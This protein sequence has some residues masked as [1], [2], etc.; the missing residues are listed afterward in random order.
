MDVEDVIAETL[1][2]AYAVDNW[3]EVREAP[4]FLARIAR[5]LLIDQARRSAII[6][7]DYMADLD[8]LGRAVTYDGM[9]TARDEL[10]RLEKI[11]DSLP[12]QQRRAFLLRRVHGYSISEVA[13]EMTLTVSTIEK[14]LTRALTTIARELAKNED[15]A[16]GAPQRDQ[17]Q[18]ESDRRGSCA[19]GHSAG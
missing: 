9:F 3:Q 13:A 2:R 19:S 16:S 4:A 17:H 10:R 14:H 6:S 8:Q 12:G 5:N 18:S 11:I 15:L 1:A 7:F